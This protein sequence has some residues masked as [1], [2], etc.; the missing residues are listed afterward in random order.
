MSN[1]WKIETEPLVAGTVEVVVP[2]FSPDGKKV[3]FVRLTDPDS[4]HE[5]R[6][7]GC[8]TVIE[9]ASRKVLQ[10]V[11]KNLV[12]VNYR[13]RG[14]GANEL[15][16]AWSP[17]SRYLTYHQDRANWEHHGARWSLFRLDTQTGEIVHFPFDPDG[18]RPQ[19]FLPSPTGRYLAIHTR[20]HWKPYTRK[21]LWRMTQHVVLGDQLVVSGPV[22][23]QAVNVIDWPKD[24]YKQEES[25]GDFHWSPAGDLLA[26]IVRF[27]DGRYREECFLAVYDVATGTRRDLFRTT[28]HL[29]HFSFS[30][31]GSTLW[32]HT[33]DRRI[34]DP[35]KRNSLYCLDVAT[36][37]S[38][39]VLEHREFFYPRC[40]PG[41]SRLL[42][43]TQLESG[44]R[45]I[46]LFTPET[47]SIV[48]VL[49]MGYCLYP[50]WSPAGD[51]FLYL[52]TKP[53]S[54]PFWTWPTEPLIQ[55]IEGGAPKKILPV[56]ASARLVNCRPSF[57]PSGREI[58][59]VAKDEADDSNERFAG[60]WYSRI[61]PDTDAA[62]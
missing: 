36:G 57:S 3:A 11:G 21:I 42:L 56:D 45:G 29:D 1:E 47:Q 34:E 5:T 44:G 16:Y 53:D 22:G 37:T 32:F 58:L 38:R 7:L 8:L 20:Q 62:H 35:Q 19:A 52:R 24:R 50:L 51:S 55:R 59:F 27:K 60:L 26:F 14:R 31:D 46:A 17:D 30:A 41:G 40:Q 4:I 49:K 33:R 13:E 10:D 61:L 9:I 18:M 23:E 15:V 28:E 54:K 6:D 43:E 39:M 25:L 2:Q 12:A 48:P